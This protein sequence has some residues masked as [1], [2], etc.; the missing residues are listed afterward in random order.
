[1]H[2]SE[3]R[4]GASLLAL[5]ALASAAAPA[6][7]ID[8]DATTADDYLFA[9]YEE[10]GFRVTVTSGHYD[11]FGPGIWCNLT[12]GVCP[13][14]FI[15]LDDSLY[16]P[17][18][19]RLTQVDGLPFDLTGFTVLDAY[20]YNQQTYQFSGCGTGCLVR[21]SRGGDQQMTAGALTFSGDAWTG[22]DWIEFAVATTV[23][24]PTIASTA[25]DD[26]VVEA[27]PVPAPPAAALLLTGLAGLVARARGRPR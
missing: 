4:S 10:D 11:F 24:A 13:D 8:F 1:M 18:V 6:A 17:S 20:Q 16:G 25:I 3:A 5:L 2:C 22:V 19:V 21:S 26:I 27:S 15:N 9:A 23:G 12:S 7:V 14:N